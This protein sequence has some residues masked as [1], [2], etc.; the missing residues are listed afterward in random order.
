MKE[1]QYPKIRKIFFWFFTCLFIIFT[2]VVVYYSLGYKFDLGAKKFLKTGALSIKTFPRGVTIYLDA[3][4]LSDTTPATLR[5]LLPREYAL[6]LEKEGYYTYQIPV[7]ITPSLISDVDV[8]LVPKMQG[9]EKIKYDFNIYKF[10]ISKRLFGEKIIAFT[11]KGIYLLDDDLRMVQKLLP[12]VLTEEEATQLEGLRE[13]NS[14]IIFW[15]RS[16]LWMLSAPQAPN[17]HEQLVNLYKAEEDIRDVFFCLHDRYLLIHDGTKV[18]ALDIDNP[19]VQ[20]SIL[21]LKSMNSRVFYETRTE[22]L[23]VKDKIPQSKTFSLFKIEMMPFIT[24]RKVSYGPL[25]N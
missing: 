19:K 2:P 11:D 17:T 1:E 9:L 14:R 22:T 21:E 7:A 6:T 8:V 25:R 24:K 3:T 16:S 5:E 4:R 12:N 10:F 18:I 13:S 20:F 15:S 23:F